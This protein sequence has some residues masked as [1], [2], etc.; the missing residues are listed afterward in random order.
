MWKNRARVISFYLPQYH[1][2]PE[3]DLWWGKGFTEWTNVRR[4]EPLFPKH[5]QPH[6]PAELG[7]YDL[8]DQEIREAQ[9]ELAR[10][11]GIEGFAYWH[12]WFEGKRLLEM[13]INQN[14]A[15]GKP[16]FPFCLAWANETWSR[17]WLG[18]EKSILIKQ[19]YSSQDDINHAEW[20]MK[21]FSDSG[22][23]TVNGRPIFLVYRPKDL[24]DS[25]RTCDVLRK[26]CLQNGLAEPYLIGIDAHCFSVDCRSLGFDA[27]LNFMPQL[28]L[29][30]DVMIDEATEAKRLRNRVLN[31][32]SAKLKVYDYE[33]AL[34]RMLS[35]SHFSHPVIPAIFPGWDNS[36]RRGGNG[37]IIVNSTPEKFE[38]ALSRMV[39]A[40]LDK[41]L[42]ERLVFL[43]AWN[44]WAE[45]NHLEPDVRHGRRYLEAVS[46]TVM[47]KKPDVR[48]DS[49]T[50]S[51]GTGFRETSGVS[52]S[53]RW[54]EELAGVRP[55]AFYLPQF[56]PIPE[57]D[58]WWGRG[59]TEWTNVAKCAPRFSGHYQPHLPAD[60]GFY[61]LRL[62]ETRE[63]QA[64]IA[65][66]YGI[67]GFCYY[68]Y[69]FSGQRLLHR[70]LDEV[71]SSGAPDFPF[72]LCWANENWTRAWDGRDSSILMEQ[73]YSEQDDRAHIA[74]LCGIF[75]DNRYI[76]VHGKPLFIVYRPA[77]L[78]DPLK[79]TQI[80]R[81]EAKRLGVGELYLCVV[82]RFQ[83][84]VSDPQKLGF[85]AAIEF[86]PDGMNMS[87]AK[88]DPQYNGH[89]VF[90]YE[91]MIQASL[92]K[93]EPGYVRYPCICPSWDNSP[94][95][96]ERAVVF[97]G[98]SPALYGKW[99][100]GAAKKLE[101]HVKEERL[102]FIN[103]WNEWGEGC[104][105]EPDTKFGKGFLEETAKVLLERNST[106]PEETVE[107]RY[108]AIQRDLIIPGKENEG[109]EELE[110]LAIEHPGFSIAYND[111][112][113]L[114]YKRGDKAKARECYEKAA[115]VDPDNSIILKNL[116]EFYWVEENRP[117]DALRLYTH[118]LSIDPKDIEALFA[119]GVICE[120]NDLAA[121]ACDFYQKILDADSSNTAAQERLDAIARAHKPHF[122]LSIPMNTQADSLEV[123]IIIPVYNKVEYTRR[124]I[125]ALVENTRGVKY[126]IILVDNGSSDGTAEFLATLPSQVHIV[127]NEINMGFA[128]GCN[129][130]A[131][132]ARAPHILLLNNDT[133]PLSGWF[134]PLAEVLNSDPSVAAVGSKLLFPDRTIQH[135]GVV[136]L[137]DRQLP[138]P[139]V[140][141]H[142]Y[143]K[144]PSDFAE[145]NVPR[146]YQALTA[147]CL[148][149]RKELF[150]QVGGFD[151][152]Y[153]NGYEDVDLCFKL[154]EKNWRLVYQ[155][156]SVLIH[157]ESK[158]GQERFSRTRENIDRLHRKW[159][160]RITPDATVRKNGS[161]RWSKEKR[162]HG[163][164]LKTVTRDRTSC[165]IDP[166]KTV[167]IVILTRNQLKY[168]KKCVESLLKHT[169]EPHEI[170]FVDNGS[171]DGTISWLREHVRRHPRNR[172]I[173]N[174]CN[175][176]YAEGNNRG[177]SNANG[178]YL[179]LLN[180][181]V[182][183]TPRWLAHLIACAE[184]E[185]STG[186]VGPKS[187]HTSGPQHLAGIA[188]DSNTLEGLDDFAIRLSE[189]Q[190][191]KRIAHWKA[192]GFC[193]L[194]KR[195]V[196]DRIGGLDPRFGIGNF[197]DDDFC[198]RAYIAGF[199]CCVAEDCFVH[200]FGSV[201]FR[202]SGINYDK[203]LRTNW[204]IFKRKWSIPA[205]TE[206]SREYRVT[207]Q[208]VSFDSARHFVS[209]DPSNRFPS[210]RETSHSKA[211]DASLNLPRKADAL[212]ETL[213]NLPNYLI[214]PEV[215]P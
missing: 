57:N 104:H 212:M 151:E 178:D 105:L 7:Y 42:E 30:P 6:V 209:L 99:L 196:I 62:V 127:N 175:L 174:G 210:E 84:D 23:L 111:M 141:R 25:K 167:S 26:R 152:E 158:S 173:E 45:G 121:D 27:T 95:K 98:N 96:K 187:N 106:T 162:I 211:Q 128:Q 85:D 86:Q 203:L 120:Q 192:V 74:F 193:M 214:Q 160:G 40:S 200:H 63:A 61:D 125:E 79:T 72:C 129:L 93:K 54:G 21:V 8:R 38:R 9:A 83:E 65:K 48:P 140:A 176:G 155:P 78:P 89:Y 207:L 145:A 166:S 195:A 49:Q 11:H 109:L 131:A 122:S 119:L 188:Y 133:E 76:R 70:P 108:F 55:I 110:R 208:G 135:A 189:R 148:L 123:S 66:E 147:A 35:G 215:H 146:I 182:V 5:Y 150:D 44:E 114:Y 29:L 116:A 68:H 81:E 46:R 1:P 92:C 201:T 143:Y 77:R 177:I 161:L 10:Q 126:E 115:F 94:R 101:G 132:A 171:T 118:I 181:D 31:I 80:W 170:I 124:C 169:S 2:I 180:N 34:E 37:I 186:I 100:A 71:V 59:F 82:E 113:V 156:Q 87:P 205:E 164:A 191:G 168:T 130:G 51:W 17:R 73:K 53:N 142:I 149:I 159:I 36:P 154:Q 75:R 19:T 136:I 107:S 137:D 64:S 117:E 202:A 33:E 20:L 15:S 194:I 103:A 134:E 4:A 197:E 91:D 43:N 18:E 102:L 22:Y 190:K 13:P 69:W 157:H 153:W 32:D 28:G 204:G 144:K 163:Y 14:L 39:Y 90:D 184:T 206:L 198:L 112:A 97:R 50:E 88:S 185:A 138:D 213:G 58:E 16:D 24:P 12:Y 183:V 60:L 41:P 56:H 139:M 47:M 179:V 52:N 3:N 67:Y 199:R 165:S 172:L